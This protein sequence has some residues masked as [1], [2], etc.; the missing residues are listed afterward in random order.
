MKHLFGKQD[1]SKEKT[2]T[3]LKRHDENIR[4]LWGSTFRDNSDLTFS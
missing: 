4:A 3:E 1:L 2:F